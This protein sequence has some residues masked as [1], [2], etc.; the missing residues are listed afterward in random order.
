MHVACKKFLVGAVVIVAL[1]VPFW[2]GFEKPADAMDEGTLLVYPELILKGQVPYRDFETFYGPA[3]LVLLSATYAGFGTSIFTERVVGLL[4]RLLGLVA[5]FVLIQRWGT[6][7]AVGCLIVAGFLLMPMKVSAFAWMGG[8]MC[9]LWSLWCIAK[10]DSGRRCFWGGIL[11]GIALLYRVDLMP[12]LA[13]ASLPLFLLMN[14]RSR[15]RFLEGVT[16]ALLPLGWLMI[17][18]GPQQ[19]FNN[20]FLFPVIYA[21]PARRLP[22]SSAGDLVHYMFFVHV[23][24]TL[25]NLAAGTMAIRSE[26]RAPAPRLLLSMALLGLGVTHQMLQRIDYSHVIFAAFISLGLLPLSLLVL[27]GYWAK[28]RPGWVQALLATTAVLILLLIAVPHLADYSR[29]ELSF[30]LSQ[31]PNTTLF[32]VHAGRSFPI[33]FVKEARDINR[34]LKRLEELSRPNQRLFVGPA[35]LRRTNYNDTYVYHLMPQLPPATYFLEMNPGSANRPDSRLATDVASADWLVLNH[36]WDVWNEPNDSI[37]Y[38][39]DAPM[40]VVRAEFELCNRYGDFEF[41]SS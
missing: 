20:L 9:V 3:N 30:N 19:L 4:Y 28:E 12:A 23:I 21:N 16:L 39:S 31:Q 14:H 24:A 7:I 22:F 5:L 8:I 13:I 17:V 6:S 29:S 41:V 34:L 25:I 1:L 11:A 26:H 40:K 35:D 33:R 18:A 10:P 38:R 32:V 15:W 36:L 2:S 27:R 37:R